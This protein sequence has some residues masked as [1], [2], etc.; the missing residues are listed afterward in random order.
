MVGLK[1][2]VGAGVGVSDGV[3][4][5]TGVGVSD[6]V[7]MTTGV[8]V[9]D[10]VGAATGLG[11]GVWVGSCRRTGLSAPIAVGVGANAVPAAVGAAVFGPPHPKHA[12]S[13]MAMR[14]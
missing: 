9:S 14:E 2:G 12:S 11:D 5:A 6:G 3:S 13:T 7:G 4:A 10:G 8:G 1:P